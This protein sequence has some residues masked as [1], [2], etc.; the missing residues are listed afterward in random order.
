MSKLKAV[1][2]NCSL[3]PGGARSSTQ[4]LLDKVITVLKGHDVECELVHA[5]DSNIRF[6]VATDM[7]GRD[8]WPDIHKKILKCDILVIG[9]PI[10]LGQRASVCQM[11]LERMDAMLSETNSVGQF[12]LYNKVAGVCIVGNEDG[13]QHV[14]AS[15]L[16]NLMQIGA[17]IPPNSEAYWVGPAGGEDDFVDVGLDDEYVKKLVSYLGNNLVLLAQ[18]L[19]E[20]PIPADG[21]M[22]SEA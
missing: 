9:T 12:P 4:A 15:I 3:K 8:G 1:L 2:F 20:R 13:A 6:G 5:V 22:E 10:W 11:V 14:G 21:N 16:Y 7:G 18:M 17:T 19:R